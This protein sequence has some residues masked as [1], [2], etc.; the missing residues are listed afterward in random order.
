[1]DGDTI[2]VKWDTQVTSVRLLNIDTPE[3]GEPGF[4][5]ATEHLRSLLAG[6][7]AVMLEFDV[8]GNHARDRY[9]RLLCYAWLNGKCLNVEMVR[10]GHS[11]YWRKYGDG[12][13]AA[14]FMAVENTGRGKR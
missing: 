2:K 7:T 1:M 10:A 14:E 6:A 11:K 13:H 8:D 12:R 4:A 3:R 5:E 9:G